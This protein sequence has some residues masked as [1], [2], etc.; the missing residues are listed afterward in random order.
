M[1]FLVNLST[2]LILSP[3]DECNAVI[4]HLRGML[5][6]AKFYLVRNWNAWR[7]LLLS[8][9]PASLWHNLPSSASYFLL[10][11]PTIHKPFSL[12]LNFRSWKTSAVSFNPSRS[13]SSLLHFYDSHFHSSCATLCC[14]CNASIALWFHCDSVNETLIYG[15]YEVDDNMNND[16]EVDNLEE[17]GR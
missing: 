15:T 5:S 11:S 1:R 8:H 3:S 13:N 14:C 12:V 2:F 10:A 6:S 17:S 7:G 16:C 4:R 9:F